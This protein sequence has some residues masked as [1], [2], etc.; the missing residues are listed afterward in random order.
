MSID[1]NSFVAEVDARIDKMVDTIQRYENPYQR[2]RFLT[3]VLPK[4]LDRIFQEMDDMANEIIIHTKP[5]GKK[6]RCGLC[7][8]EMAKDDVVTLTRKD[9]V[10]RLVA[11]SYTRLYRNPYW[12]CRRCWARQ[13]QRQGG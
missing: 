3:K 12:V 5:R 11:S 8:E 7:L 9:E 4:E 13:Q 10:F 6:I 1:V 2:N